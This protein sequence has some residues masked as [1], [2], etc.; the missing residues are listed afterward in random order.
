MRQT[1][2][3]VPTDQETVSSFRTR[4][5][6]CHTSVLWTFPLTLLSMVLWLSFD[7]SAFFALLIFIFE[8][9]CVGTLWRAWHAAW[10]GRHGTSASGTVARITTRRGATP[11]Q[12]VYRISYTFNDGQ[13]RTF[14]GTLR[15]TRP[16]NWMFYDGRPVEVRKG[17]HHPQRNTLAS[18]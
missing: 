16:H 17:S 12:T 10:L 4:L 18:I 13:G 5:A 11:A 1:W 15:V 8:I 14:N 3:P 2:P 9:P 6:R 7:E